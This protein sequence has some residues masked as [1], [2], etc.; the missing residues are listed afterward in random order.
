MSSEYVVMS[1]EYVVMSSE[2]VVTI[3]MS[4]KSTTKFG[5][6]PIGE[7]EYNGYFRL[8]VGVVL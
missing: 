5:I 3:G 1:S 7:K 2:Y 6:S 4:M 8:P